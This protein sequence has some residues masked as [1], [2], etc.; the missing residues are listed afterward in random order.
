M[1]NYGHG[2]QP[3]SLPTSS[4]DSIGIG[5]KGL[6]TYEREKFRSYFMAVLR[7]LYSSFT[8]SELSGQSL[9]LTYLLSKDV[10]LRPLYLPA[11]FAFATPSR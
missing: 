9:L 6:L 10:G 1:D 11:A 4:L 2:T 7:I 8:Y 5:L 3:Y